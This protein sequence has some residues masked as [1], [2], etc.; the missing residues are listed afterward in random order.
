MA[1]FLSRPRAGRLAALLCWTALVSGGMPLASPSAAPGRSEAGPDQGIW[2]MTFEKGNRRCRLVL[3]PD[4][5]EAGFRAMLPVGCHRAFPSLKD[6][7]SW[8]STP[9]GHVELETVTGQPVLDFAPSGGPY[10]AATAAEDEV[11]TL[12]PLDRKR[13]AALASGESSKSPAAS[14]ADKPTAKQA[15]PAHKSPPPSR[16]VTTAEVAGHYAVIRSGKDTGCMV[17][18]DDKER[19]P[20]ESMKARLAPACGD[21]GIV[22]F[23]PAGWELAHNRLVLIARKGHSTELNQQDDGTWANAPARGRVLVLKRL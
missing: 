17:T 15:T 6:V 12:T 3:Y 20:K 19:G 7:T 2:D 1:V 5:A 16:P 14:Q 8:I 4:K 11:Y 23:D 21:Q 18:L 9:D 22:I 13:Q 10:L